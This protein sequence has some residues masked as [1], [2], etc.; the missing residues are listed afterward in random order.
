VLLEFDPDTG[1]YVHPTALVVVPRQGG[2]TFETGV[3]LEE[4]AFTTPR[5]RCWYTAQ[6]QSDA[7]QWF[8]DEHL[9]MLEEQPAFTG[10]YR[11]RLSQGSHQVTWSH[12]GSI[13][14]CFSPNRAALHGKQS[15]LVDIDELWAFAAAAGDELLQAIG[16]TQATRPGAQVIMQSAAGDEESTFLI[17]QLVAARRDHDNGVD[18]G[19]VL[20]EYG[21][22]DGLD[23]TDPDIVARYHPAVG[24]T[25]AASYLSTERRRLGPDGFARA[26]G[27]VQVIPEVSG[28]VL[29]FDQW[30]DGQILEDLRPPVGACALVYDVAHDRSDAA[31]CAAWAHEGRTV[32]ALLEHHPF[33]GW[34]EGRFR[35]LRAALKP[36]ACGFDAYG[37]GRDIAGRLERSGV[38]L[39]AM[40]TSDVVEAYEGFLSGHESRSI[41]HLP[42]APLDQALVIA[43]RRPIGDAFAWGRRASSG[44]IAPLVAATNAA[45]LWGRRPAGRPVF[46]SR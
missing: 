20:V 15:D 30:H 32:V 31:I 21:V 6:T 41:G 39:E 10:R 25:I 5:A 38:H 23:A 26:Y 42:A 14:R 37:P 27:A 12:T 11:R 3:L 1:L 24:H 34:V 46:R 22:P 7:E 44:S 35:E 2:K 45:W 4:R 16:P 13:V 36:A 40:T 18:G 17:E 29:P 28:R 8:R 33:V 43:G 19:V 9:P